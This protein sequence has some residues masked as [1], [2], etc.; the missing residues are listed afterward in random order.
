MSDVLDDISEE[1]RESIAVV[2]MAWRFP[3]APA[4]SGFCSI[5][6]VK[7][8]DEHLD[9]P[10][11]M[12]GLILV[13]SLPENKIISPY[14]GIGWISSMVSEYPARAGVIRSCRS[15]T[16]QGNML[17]FR[18]DKSS[19]E[20]MKHHPVAYQ[21]LEQQPRIGWATLI[22]ESLIVVCTL[23]GHHDAVAS[24]ATANAYPS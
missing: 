16:W 17:L 5:G 23:D 12:P 15:G 20:H 10:S 6:S 3:G 24:S 14:K 13:R 9:A 4:P 21:M 7:T 22:P 1:S 11:S 2:G 18:A 8:P 19:W